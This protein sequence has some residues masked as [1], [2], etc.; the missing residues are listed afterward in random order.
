MTKNPNM[1][2]IS[3]L[4]LG[5]LFDFLFWGQSMGINFTIYA[6][7]CA[8]GGF[9][10]LWKAKLLPARGIL[11][12]IP[13]L[14]FFIGVPSFRTEPLTAFLGALFASLLGGLAAISYLGGR[15]F[16][17]SLADYF[18]GFM[19][20]LGSM[21]GRPI[22]FSMAVRSEEKETGVSRPRINIWPIIR[23]IIITIPI[24][25]IF[26][27]LLAS[28]DAIFSK[29]LNDFIKLFFEVE[30]IPEYIFRLVYI[31]IFS[32]A[33][34]GVFLHASA[35]SKDEKLLGADKPLVPQFLG[36]AETTIILSSVT[37]L[38]AAFVI[39]QFRYFFGGQANVTAA[40]FTYAEY[41]R[42]GFGELVTVAFFSLL[43]VLSL[44]TLTRRESETQRRLFSVLTGLIVALVIVMLVSAYQR[45]ILYESAYGFSRLRTYTHVALVWIGLLLAAAVVL[46]SLRRG[47]TFA[48]ALLVASLGFA[49]S[50]AVLNVDAL[51]VRENVDRAMHGQG[52]DVPYLVS[53]ST[54]SV[55]AL[56]EVFE[57]PTS[58]DLT[59]DAVGAVLFCRLRA[60]HAD[61]DW[62]SFTLS[63]WQAD[64]ALKRVGPQL[65]GYR[66]V[67][68]SWPI[69]ILTPGH[70]AYNCYG[71]GID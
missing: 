26:A 55:P 35:H 31:L 12:L 57:S 30:R 71:G 69:R 42:R 17:Y 1:L 14:L 28:A 4:F 11:W 60:P 58:P 68:E 21:I 47:R 40:G 48:L 63:R 59:R 25:A 56:A 61:L 2:W 27:A 3:A 43:M 9:L 44:D 13:P 65:Q 22:A 53:L 34:A 8:L 6:V 15:W 39:V 7:I 36:F 64:E 19:G 33:L 10:L 37:V 41:A 38:F 16:Q 23:G 5:W 54:E 18:S 67:D 62:R 70:V 66:V 52:L 49:V 50:L 29:E 45:L 32:Y 51:I 24:V 46:E 20:L